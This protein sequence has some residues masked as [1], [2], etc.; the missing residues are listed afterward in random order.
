MPEN[1]EK[2]QRVSGD[3]GIVTDDSGNV[4]GDSGT[5]PKNGHDETE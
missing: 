2:F 3:S 1:I 4:T 5:G